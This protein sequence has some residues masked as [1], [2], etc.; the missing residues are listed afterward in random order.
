MRPRTLAVV[1]LAALLVLSGCSALDGSTSDTDGQLDS[2]TYPAGSGPNGFS[3]VSQV[4]VSH[5]EQLAT[6]SYRLAFNLTHVRGGQT[7]NTTTVV[8]SNE[9]QGRQLLSAEL[10]GRTVDQFLTPEVAASRLRTKNG[11]RFQSQQLSRPMSE[12]HYRGATPGQLLPTVLRA[13]NYTANRTETRGNRT[14]IVYESTTLRANASGQL[15]DEVESVS[16]TVTIDEQGRI[17]E[18]ELLVG[19]RTDGAE[20]VFYQQYRTESV[21]NVSVTRPAWVENATE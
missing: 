2:V 13:G 16:G 20:E 8:A 3:N 21:G 19:G 12:I 17:W 18:A 4:L 7:A 5:Q 14:L 6:D 11:T 15:P 9:S 1:S 10:P